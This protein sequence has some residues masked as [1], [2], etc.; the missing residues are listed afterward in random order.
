MTIPTERMRALRWGLELLEAIQKD[1]SVLESFK[2]RAELV[3]R[4]YPTPITLV[5]LIGSG[6][7]R[8]SRDVAEAIDEAGVLFE[9]LQRSGLAKGETLRLA[10]FT[11]RH[12][13]LR[14]TALDQA[15]HGTLGGLRCWLDVEE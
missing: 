3:V 15:R 13:P 6:A 4:R 11:L 7:E 9:D 1:D 10:M 5:D 12:F 8:L 2:R 14:G